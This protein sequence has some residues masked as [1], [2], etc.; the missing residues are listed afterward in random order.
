MPRNTVV[1]ADGACSRNGQP[2]ASAGIG[3][4]V[5]SAPSNNVSKPYSG[6]RQTN[7]EAS[8]SA[9][10]EAVRVAHSMGKSSVTVKT[11]SKLVAD[12]HSHYIP[13]WES[14]GWKNSH[15]KPVVNRSEFEN[16]SR[17]IQDSGMKVRIEHTPANSGNRGQERAT[18]LARGSTSRSYGE[19]NSGGYGN[20]EGYGGGNGN[21]G[22]Y[23]G[24]YGNNGG[25]Y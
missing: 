24:G 3:V 25:Y 11:D 4:H 6:A 15:N 19:G 8:I 5:P 10:T 16:M 20:N 17:T 22:G 21:K 2:G 12:A 1:Y 23:G 18:N 13:K 7:N 14:N 9:A